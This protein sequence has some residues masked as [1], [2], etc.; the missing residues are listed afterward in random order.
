MQLESLVSLY[1]TFIHI[2]PFDGL[3]FYAFRRYLRLGAART[4][5]G[6][7]AL[8][9]VE[10]AVQVQ[11]SGVYDLAEPTLAPGESVA[12]FL[13]AEEDFDVDAAAQRDYHYVNLHQLALMHLIG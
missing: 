6:Y 4:A 12:D 10:G 1:Y 11:L 8:L 7:L 3:I 9:A 2:A 5:L 13:A